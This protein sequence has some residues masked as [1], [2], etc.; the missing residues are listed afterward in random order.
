MFDASNQALLERL[1]ELAA[2][3]TVSSF[4][5][6]F[7]RLILR[8]VAEAPR[9][10]AGRLACAALLDVE[11]R[12]H[13]ELKRLSDQQEVSFADLRSAGEKH[14][15]GLESVQDFTQSIA[16]GVDPLA[17]I[18]Q[19]V[20]AECHYHLRHTEQV[21]AALER[22]ERLGTADP[23]VHFALGYN[24]YALALETFT[25]RG[26]KEGELTV[27]DPLSF[28]VQCLRAVGAFE[29]GLT[30]NEL[31][32]QLYW[33][34]GTVLE[35]AGLTDAAQDAYDKSAALFAESEQREGKAEPPAAG[36]GAAP[37]ITEEEVRRAGELL[38]GR[39]AL[40][41]IMD[42]DAEDGS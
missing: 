31:D 37:A 25:E 6:A 8:L 38:K 30:G 41:D 4:S 42:F 18:S 2:L 3:E 40:S 32:A 22:A 24:R 10:E 1:E 15:I 20:L 35:A 39:F 14:R 29:N 34:I 16:V 17:A 13:R 36:V 33:W 12:Y 11:L 19:L 5:V 23:L 21:V 9:E 27:R 28:Q 26:E 7:Y